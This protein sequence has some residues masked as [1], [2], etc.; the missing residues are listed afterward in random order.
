MSGIDFWI[1]NQ[2]KYFN[3]I[4]IYLIYLLFAV[5]FYSHSI[6]LILV[7]LLVLWAVVESFFEKRLL[8]GINE[9]VILLGIIIIWSILATTVF[10]SGNLHRIGKF[11]YYSP[12]LLSPWFQ[13]QDKDIKKIT[14]IV[15]LLMII[16][17]PLSIALS[18]NFSVYTINIFPILRHH[19]LLGYYIS[20]LCLISLSI[21]LITEGKNKQKLMWGGIALVLGFYVFLT[22]SRAFYIALMIS[23]F[24]MIWFL[25]RKKIVYF[26]ISVGIISLVTALVFP[27]FVDR[28]KTIFDTKHFSSNTARLKMWKISLSII[29]LNFKNFFLGVGIEGWKVFMPESIHQTVPDWSFLLR[30]EHLHNIYLNCWVETGFIGLLMLLLFFFFILRKLYLKFNQLSSGFSKAFTVGVLFSVVCYLIGGFFDILAR[31]HILLS[32]YL[33]IA[34]A[35]G[36]REDAI[37]E[38]P[39]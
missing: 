22:G 3:T 10:G 7:C 23:A 32:L 39:R 12:L 30:F 38:N 8:I 33:F 31:P 13:L 20:S 17:F 18:K 26:L 4:K 14:F 35:L 25:D 21:F 16:T 34:A 1:N 29:I 2:N 19:T 28:V 24:I 37:Q 27:D 6:G 15:V 36:I 11:I 9:Y 5:F